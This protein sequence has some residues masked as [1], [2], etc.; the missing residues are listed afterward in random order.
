MRRTQITRRDVVDRWALR[1]FAAISRP[2][3]ANRLRVLGYHGIEDSGTFAR[4]LEFLRR[5][6]R[7]V[8][9]S[10]VVASSQ[11]GPPLP[12]NAVWITFDDGYESVVDSALP[13]LEQHGVTAT[14]FVCPGLIDPPSP[15]WFDLVGAVSIRDRAEGVEG[16]PSIS[17]VSRMKL[18][19]DDARRQIVADMARSVDATEMQQ[20]RSQM[21]GE[22]DLR[23]WVGAGQELGNHTWD[24]P[25]LPRASAESSR[26][27]IES[28]HDWLRSRG[29]LISP[30]LFAYPNG[31]LDPR[32][33]TVLT[34]LGYAGAVLFDHRLNK[35][36]FDPMRISRLRISSKASTARFEAIL[37]GGHSGLLHAESSV[38]RRQQT[39]LRDEAT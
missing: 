28:A 36:T 9:G 32:C 25:I 19:D 16:D 15:A 21:V 6:Y 17:P 14:L 12:R 35:R 5:H 8:S 3:S 10:E 33:E 22:D 20:L 1:P 23:A 2:L 34:E 27:Q 11:G 38:R 18:L 4:Q 13:L 24:H 30:F 26:A 7:T 37:S 31:D 29:L 39:R